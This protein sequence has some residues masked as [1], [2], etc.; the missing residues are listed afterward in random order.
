[1][2]D[3]GAGEKE[4]LA[5]RL[6]LPGAVVILDERLG[7][8]HAEALKLAFT[9]TPGILL[10]AKVEGRIPRIDALLAHLDSFG[11]SPVGE[12]TRGS[13]QTGWRMRLPTF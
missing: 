5:L 6:Q 1:M 3:L 7:R 9:G 10:R 4:V 2:A 13:T 12:N 8:L 11:I